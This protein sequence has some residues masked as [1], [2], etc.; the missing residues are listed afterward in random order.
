MKRKLLFAVLASLM[1]AMTACGSENASEKD[2]SVEIKV[3]DNDE[4][5]E[6]SEGE[7]KVAE[8]KSEE[9]PE[10]KYTIY[11]KSQDKSILQIENYTV[12][13]GME[14][15]SGSCGEHK[16]G[17]TYKS[18]EY[19]I[20]NVWVTYYED[21][22][23]DQWKSEMAAKE[24]TTGPEMMVYNGEEREVYVSDAESLISHY[25]AVEGQ[26]G[27]YEVRI[28]HKEVDDKITYEMMSKCVDA[29]FSIVILVN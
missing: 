3:N 28:Y 22:T 19:G 7:S 23:V 9:K 20:V 15:A 13:E 6:T 11:L 16:H 8:E 14:S 26:Q 24:R 21:K 27:M 17:I 29:Y 2:S 5:A 10:D 12:P 25:Y 18:N 4:N 1:L